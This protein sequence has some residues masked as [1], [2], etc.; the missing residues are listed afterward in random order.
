MQQAHV[1]H[2]A[3]TDGQG[4]PS[5]P[6]APRPLAGVRVLDLS[7]VLAGP[8]AS[9]ILADYG[10]D[11]IKVERPGSG[12]DTRAWGPPWWQPA[13]GH[14]DARVA[15]YFVC[16]NRGKRSV[17]ID[18]ASPTGIEQ[19]RSLAREA[20]VLIENYK[21]GQLA[22]YGLDARSLQALN[23]RL[24][25]CSIT[26]Y[27]Q[28]GPLAHKAGYDFAIQAEGGLMSITGEPDGEPQKVGVAVVDLMTGV[29]AATAILAAL[30]ERQRTGRGRVL[31]V[32]LLDVQVAM[33]ANQASNQLIGQ[34]TPRRMGNAHPN[35]VPYQAFPTRDGHLVLAVGNDGQ[36]QRFCEVAGHP[37]VARD[38][39]FATNPARVEHREA[40]VAQIAAWTRT[41][42]TA[43][44]VQALDAA[45]VPC[46]PINDIAQV[47][48]H[49]QVQARG[50]VVPGQ[51]DRPPMVAHPVLFDGIRPTAERPPPSLNSDPA[52]W[53]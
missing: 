42:D 52:Q 51:S 2:T 18:I 47:M 8:W 50:L 1:T 19:V 40:L 29:Y 5:A 14:D 12:D 10:A 37:E 34:R 28:T 17:A 4:E 39:R 25:Y 24:I 36:F 44:W 13:G 26:G 53:S 6:P 27:G 41:R 33:L 16:A 11:V 23:P 35:I 3:P 22:K 30:H 21:V 32:A 45:G 49:P 20:D 31:D 43:D 38:V 9:Q 48:Q 7:R 15:A 46:A